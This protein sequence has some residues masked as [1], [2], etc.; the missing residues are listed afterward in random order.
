MAEKQSLLD[1]LELLF[2]ADRYRHNKVMVALRSDADLQALGSDMRALH[3]ANIPAAYALP[4]FDGHTELTSRLARR[5]LPLKAIERKKHQSPASL[6]QQAWRENRIPILFSPASEDYSSEAKAAVALSDELKIKRLYFAGDTAGLEIDGKFQHFVSPETASLALS[7]ETG[8]SFNRQRLRVALESVEQKEKEIV[9]LK[10]EEGQLFAELFTHRGSGTLLAKNTHE[11]VRDA[12]LSDVLAISAMISPL[13][14]SGALLPIDEDEV[15]DNISQF[16]VFV[17]NGVVVAAA[18]IREFGDFCELGKF[19][20]L[21]RYRGKGI[22]RDLTSA[23]IEKARLKDKTG[24]FALVTA[25]KM[26]QF[27]LQIGMEVCKREELPDQW[28]Q[29]YD[30]SR[31]STALRLMF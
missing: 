11:V 6:V 18:R 15:A 19:C 9:F 21:P 10:A 29:Q 12:S 31:N 1:A 5:G 4:G 20:T 23:L 13:V 16:S 7:F 28:R 27:F 22:A 25:E 2:Y 17:A 8:S 26:E 30:L 24:V 3:L 14:S